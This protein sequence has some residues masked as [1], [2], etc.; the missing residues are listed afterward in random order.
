[1][2]KK[3]AEHIGSILVVALVFGILIVAFQ[4]HQS[5]EQR[6]R[7]A[8]VGPYLSLQ[9]LDFGN[10][11]DRSLFKET[12][13]AFRPDSVEANEA[14]LQAID[15]YREAQFT[16]PSLKT[17]EG[18]R[19]LSWGMA[20]R[21]SGMYGSFILVYAVVLLLTLYAAQTV[22]VFRF[23]SV[24]QHRESALR[25]LA[26]H[27]NGFGRETRRLGYARY[28]VRGGVLLF[29]AIAKGGAYLVLFAPAYVI[30]YALKTSVETNTILF[31]IVLGL[32]SNGL[33]ITYANKFHTLLVT[34]SR[35][36]YVETALAKGLS[37]QWIWNRPGGI[38]TSSL[39]QIGKKFPSH[40][41]DHMYLNAR[42]QYLPTLKE[43]GSFL[44][45]GLII[46]EMALNIQGH[47]GYE[48]LQRILY[49]EYDVALAMIFGIFLVLKVT[50]IVIDWQSNRE[51]RKFGNVE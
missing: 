29:R 20:A 33:L 7:R 36:G 27:V 18:E 21:L 10:P 44:I 45:T 48:L 2:G 46:A 40:V 38:R 16:D 39:L 42:T 30:G 1:M 49:K 6:A 35:K 13:N 41:L 47:Y 26:E 17:V 50:E 8:A 19:G 43:Q 31:M 15:A 12:L 25:E 22:A 14:L 5:S 51:A 32:V 37:G 3:L 11:L 9:F 4:H 34:E 24:K 28:I 23:V